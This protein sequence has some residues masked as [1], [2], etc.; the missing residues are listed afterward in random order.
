MPL[1][2]KHIKVKNIFAE[3]NRGILLDLV[4]FV[5]QLVLIRLLTR[6][7]IELIR[8]ASADEALAK[9]VL[10]LFFLG[11]FVLPPAGAILKRWHFHQRTR[12]RK[13]TGAPLGDGLAGCLFHPIIYSGALELRAAGR[14]A[15]RICYCVGERAL[16]DVL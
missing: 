9:L 3:T 8:R 4:V 16:A 6:Y 15:S 2:V 11:M 12:F 5:L 7:F 14:W 13:Q 10:G 1:K